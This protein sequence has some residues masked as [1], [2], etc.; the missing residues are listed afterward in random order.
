MSGRKEELFLKIKPCRALI[1]VNNPM[2]ESYASQISKKI[3]TTYAH[4]VKILKKL[5]NEGL[6]DRRDKG[7]KMI[8]ET[9]EQGRRVARAAQTLRSEVKDQSIQEDLHEAVFQA[10]DWNIVEAENNLYIDCLGTDK[11]LIYLEELEKA[12]ERIQAVD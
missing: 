3:D 7:R 12:V 8:A 5:D 4:T 1:A 11:A 2:T 9:T 6:I 10:Q